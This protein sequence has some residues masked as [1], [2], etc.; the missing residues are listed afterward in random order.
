[1]N[2]EETCD[3]CSQMKCVSKSFPFNETALV[4]KVLD[5]MFALINLNDEKSINLKC[6]PEKAIQLREHFLSV[7]PGYHMNKK[8]WNTI[9]LDGTITP[10]KIQDWIDHSYELVV[11]GMTKKQQR[12]GSISLLSIVFLAYSLYCITSPLPPNFLIVRIENK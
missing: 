3:Y 5:K 2:I 7:V 11:A 9:Y 1:M 10:K 4:F 12:F 6:D 8:H